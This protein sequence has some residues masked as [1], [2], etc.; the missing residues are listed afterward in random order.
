MRL[1]IIESPYAG[2]VE[3]NLRYLRACMKDSLGRGEAPFAPHSMYTQ[4][5]VL[6]D[7]DP[8]ERRLG[9]AAGFEWRFVAEATI[10]YMD[11]GISSGMREGIEH[12]E[13]LGYPVD[14]RKLGGEWTG[15]GILWEG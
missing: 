9:I 12:A 14:Y 15:H 7:N 3:R 10:V 5:G 2:D 6:D 13:K 4:V 11:L 8:D 1:V